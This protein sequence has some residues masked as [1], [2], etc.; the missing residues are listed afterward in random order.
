MRKVRVF[1]RTAIAIAVSTVFL[2]SACA[3][4]GGGGA[5][6]QGS[7][8][9]TPSSG[10]GINVPLTTPATPTSPAPSLAP[11]TSP[12][13][14]YVPFSTPTHI[15]TVNP[16]VTSTYS[17][18]LVNAQTVDLTG[19]GVDNVVVGGVQSHHTL[20]TSSADSNNWRN[21]RIS[22]LGWA[23]GQLVDQTSQ[24]FSGSDNIVVGTSGV[25]FGNFAGN[26]RQS[27]FIAPYSD[28]IVSD[29]QVHMFVNNGNGFTR[30]NI[31]LPY[32]MDSPDSAVFSH[33]GVDNV[34]S[35]NYPNTTF[36]LGST[37]GNFRAYNVGDIGGQS[38]AAGNFTGN[39]ETTFVIGDNNSSADRRYTTQLF[40]WQQDSVTGNISMNHIGTLPMPIFN[41][42]KYDSIL[43]DAGTNRNN[44]VRVIKYDFDGSGKD[45]LFTISMPN[46][47]ASTLK[48]S[49]QF[50][51]NNGAGIFT[52]VTDTTVSGYDMT[53]A[54]SLNP[55]IVNT[56]NTGLS[57]I[58]LPSPD[59]TQILVQVSQGKYVASFG[60]VISDFQNQVKNI[61]GGSYGARNQT[62]FVK[63]PDGNLY[64]MDLVD[65]TVNNQAH[66]SV[67]LSKLG[68]T[69][70]TVNA[71]RVISA[72][73]QQWP[74]MT[75]AAANTVLASTGKT[76]FGATIIDESA[77]WQPYGSMSISTAR[78]LV[79]INGYLAGVNLDDASAV[80]TDSLGRSFNTN[81]KSMNVSTLNAF[82][83]NTAH[84]DQHNLTSHAEYLVNGNVTTYSGIRVGAEGQPGNTALGTGQSLGVLQRPTQYTFGVPEIYRKGGFSYGAQ[85][86]SLNQ[87]PWIAFGGSWGSVNNTGIMDNVVT[88]R[89]SGFSAQG[90]L[91]H[92]TTNIQPGLITKVN[93]MIGAWAETGYRYTDDSLGDFGLYAGV[94]PVVLSGNIEARM[95]TS[96]DNSGNVVY[97]SKNM[98][99]QNQATGYIRAMYTNMIDKKTMYRFS[100]MGTQQG[101]YRLMHELRFWLD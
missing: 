81:L 74:W 32:G 56:R 1:N 14:E 46:N 52:D 36:F 21:S 97:T 22:V 23:N 43:G 99:V 62:N 42:A 48:S 34:V 90:S 20:L 8:P 80:V 30:Y 38:I 15:T 29:S 4:G 50:L 55:L 51:K 49:I 100:A 47:M 41:Q 101:Q 10:P 5:N 94:K 40:N 25:K 67:Y 91:M 59:G 6:S 60:N 73:K 45:S 19:T 83:Y 85:Y 7:T 96:V 26:G 88:Y 2:L 71:A 78:G 65:N 54:A 11:S 17:T 35:L 27:M 82:N 92:V 64:L 95:P 75:D 79:P 13:S 76:W 12:T 28:G 89:N 77:I 31:S 18:S 86:T 53:K 37:T 61:I 3:G 72:I 68:S 33:N 9:P 84:T 70:T 66:K 93:N 16:L 24:W 87:N 63:G 58:V 57:D 98:M 69:N 44:T 39:G